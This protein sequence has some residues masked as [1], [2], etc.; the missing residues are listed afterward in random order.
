MHDEQRPAPWR[1]YPK[2]WVVMSFQTALQ[3]NTIP[4]P[5][6]HH[7]PPAT[8]PPRT[9]PDTQTNQTSTTTTTTTKTKT[10]R[11][12]A[13]HRLTRLPLLLPRHLHTYATTSSPKSAERASAQSGGAR[14]IDAKEQT[15]PSPSSADSPVPDAL[16]SSSGARGRTGG[17]PALEASHAAPARPKIYNASVHGGTASLTEEQKAEVDRHNEEFEE[18]HGKA[19]RAEGDKVNKSFWAGT[20]EMAGGEEAAKGEDVREGGKKGE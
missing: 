9:K 4:S 14:S 18:K 8:P 5:K 10:T 13:M 6:R 20:G 15:S 2:P 1:S 12:T 3:Q 19:P 11:T 16:A 7:F 17:G